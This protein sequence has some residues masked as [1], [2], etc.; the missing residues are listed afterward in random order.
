MVRGS[1]FATSLRAFTFSIPTART[2]VRVATLNDSGRNPAANF[3]GGSRSFDEYC[4]H[5]NS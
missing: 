5:E 2:S 4:T 3:L 1:E